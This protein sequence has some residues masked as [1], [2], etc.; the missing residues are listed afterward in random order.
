MD[1]EYD[2]VRIIILRLGELKKVDNLPNEKSKY[3]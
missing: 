1:V 2:A 3:C